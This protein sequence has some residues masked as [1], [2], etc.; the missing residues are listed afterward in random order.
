MPRPFIHINFAIDAT[1][2]PGHGFAELSVSCA[3]DWQRVHALREQYDAVAVGGRTWEIDRPRLNVRPERLGREPSRQ[4]ARVVFAG[5]KT[6][7]S[8]PDVVVVSD[9]VHSLSGPLR[10]LHARGIASMLVEGGPTL[11]RSFLIQGYADQMTVFAR[12]G[13]PS[14]AEFRARQYLAGL[15]PLIGIRVCC[16]GFLLLFDCREFGASA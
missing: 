14:A 12:A 5:N 7:I 4:P 16:E 8:E 9:P 11:I 1:A 13:S 15:P 10:E 6:Q 2:A 3:A